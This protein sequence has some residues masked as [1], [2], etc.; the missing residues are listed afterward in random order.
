V[1]GVVDSLKK[2]ITKNGGIMMFATIQDTSGS[3]ELIIFPRA[4]ETTQSVWQEGQ[5]VLVQGK[6]PKEAGDNK[7]F[8]EKAALMNHENALQITNQLSFGLSVKDYAPQMQ[9]KSVVINLNKVE[10]KAHTESLK[11][12]FTA[13]PGDY[14]VYIKVGASTIRAQSMIDWNSEI[15]QQLEKVVGEGKVEVYE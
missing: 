3:M 14:Q 5:I 1:G 11:K 2:K 8:V 10:L 15:L 12:L 9:E 6:T 13:N 7:I 4:Y